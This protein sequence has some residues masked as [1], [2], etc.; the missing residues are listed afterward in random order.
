MR[1]RRLGRT[2]ARGAADR[3]EHDR[4]G[5]SA[6]EVARPGTDARLAAELRGGRVERAQ[7][8]TLALDALERTRDVQ[9]PSRVRTASRSARRSCRRARESG[10]GRGSVRCRRRRDCAGERAHDLGVEPRARV[11]HPGSTFHAGACDRVALSPR[12][13]A[14]RSAQFGFRAR[15]RLR[16]E[17]A[18]IAF[19]EVAFAA[20]TLRRDRNR[21]RPAR[22]PAR[23]MRARARALAER[24]LEPGDQRG[25]AACARRVPASP[26]EQRLGVL[27][28]R[29]REDLGLRRVTRGLRDDSLARVLP[30]GAPVGFGLA[31]KIDL[32]LDDE[33]S[34]ARVRRSGPKNAASPSLKGCCVS[35][36]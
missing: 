4:R 32:R 34:C 20:Q 7:T 26:F 11:A 23:A 17:F 25:K 19:Q 8:R 31:P 18:R 2:R 10:L 13:R 22:L 6:R 16:R 33:K 28:R 29:D 15:A 5:D 36:R 1:L 21:F 3:A 27:A 9:P 30:S 12:G 35:I 14:L 24:A